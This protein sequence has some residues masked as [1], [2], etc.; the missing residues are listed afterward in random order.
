MIINLIG[1]SPDGDAFDFGKTTGSPIVTSPGNILERFF[2]NAF[3]RDFIYL[4]NVAISISPPPPKK[5]PYQNKNDKAIA[6]SRGPINLYFVTK[7]V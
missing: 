6:L 4:T 2:W 3:H 1:T 5:K 7:W